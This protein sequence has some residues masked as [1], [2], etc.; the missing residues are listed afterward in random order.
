M[1]KSIVLLLHVGFWMCYL[2][3]F[4]IMLGV[5]FYG[6]ETNTKFEYY[7]EILFQFIIIP[8]VI[9][10][11]AFYFYL[12][13]KYLQ[14]KKF[15]STIAIGVLIAIGVSFVGALGLYLRNDPQMDTVCNDEAIVGPILFVILVILIAGVVALVIRGFITW[16]EEMKWKEELQQ[17]NHEMEMAL[18]KA[19]LDPH[20]LFNTINNIDVLILKNAK[21]ASNYLNKLSEIMRFM[22]FE[23]K[24]EEI[25]L[26]KEI[27]YIEEYIALQR[28]RTANASYVNF[29]INGEAQQKK[30]APMVFIPF[31]ENAFKHTT[32]KKLDNAINIHIDIEKEKVQLLCENKFDPHRKPQDG[33]N[34][35]GNELIQKRL[36]LIYPQQHQLELVRQDDLY[37]V[38]LTINN[39]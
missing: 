1:K 15:L 25:L 7:F 4:F 31:I 2:T 21:E 9:S 27:R 6:E 24:T 35:L 13:P 19:Q 11:Y 36:H 34:G 5:Y 38:Q 12:F 20:F 14:Q 26:S 39:G 3:L 18:V 30:I 28:I 32:N 23:T 10:F 37:S 33:D 22:L 8:S 29:Q 17:K 16:F